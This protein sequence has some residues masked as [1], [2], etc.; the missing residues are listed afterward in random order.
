MDRASI[1]VVAELDY[2]EPIDAG[3]DVE[4]VRWADGDGLL[5][6]CA[7]PEPSR[8]WPA[9]RFDSVAP[10]STARLPVEGAGLSAHRPRLDSIGLA[11]DEVDVAG[12]DL[13]L[14]DDP[15]GRRPPELP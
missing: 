10:R 11:G 14:A 12:A 9:S 1:D 5:A 13:W 7:A 15:S 4:L 8:Q 6:A 3:E 2:R